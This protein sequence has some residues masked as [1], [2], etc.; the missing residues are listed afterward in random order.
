MT[1][2]QSAEDLGQ[3]YARLGR[4]LERMVRSGVRAPDTVI[5]D[6]C[7]FAWMHLIPRR[8]RVRPETLLGWLA[9][10]ATHQALELLRRD[11]RELSWE[12]E[13]EQV[14]DGMPGPDPGPDE[15]VAQRERLAGV[16]P[17]PG[18][19]RL[20]PL[21]TTHASATAITLLIA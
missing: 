14:P 8:Q 4:Q 6:A 12:Q 15:L 21:R 3:L 11:Q 5:E 13:L 1:E 10:T 7:Q 2:V 16:V 20:Q 19:L 18:E 9:T 17:V